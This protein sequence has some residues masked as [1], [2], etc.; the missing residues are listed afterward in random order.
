MKLAIAVAF[1]MDLTNANVWNIGDVFA[2]VFDGNYNVYDNNGVSKETINNGLG[3]E[4]TGCAFNGDK[5]KLYT[6]S[7]SATKVVVFDVTP[8]HNVSQIIDTAVTSPGGDS[9]STV[10]DDA[11]NFYVG[12][13]DSNKLV[14]TYN[15]AGV[16]QETYSVET[17]DRGSD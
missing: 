13:P 5:S 6:T 8:P 16:L 10:F 7:F 17:E 11:G 15:A 4:T 3:G 14:H 2:G 9:E 1:L 12:N